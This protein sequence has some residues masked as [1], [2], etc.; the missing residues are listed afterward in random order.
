M[1]GSIYFLFTYV[2][3]ELLEF[4]HSHRMAAENTSFEIGC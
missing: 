1:Y 2:L 4:S 3:A